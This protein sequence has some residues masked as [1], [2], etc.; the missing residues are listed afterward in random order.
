MLPQAFVVVGDHN[1]HVG[2]GVKCAKEVRCPHTL[3]RV[4]FDNTINCSQVYTYFYMRLCMYRT[5]CLCTVPSLLVCPPGCWALFADVWMT[6]FGVMSTYVHAPRHRIC[7]SVAYHWLLGRG[8]T[9][10]RLLRGAQSILVGE[11]KDC[12]HKAF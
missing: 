9:A 3:C 11:I 5:L 2:L 4:V 10:R 12:L 6:L 8:G 7:T 1:G